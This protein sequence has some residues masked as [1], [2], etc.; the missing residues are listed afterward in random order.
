MI[1]PGKF[2][3]ELASL[4]NKYSMENETNTPDFILAKY[5]IKCLDAWTWSCNR[6]TCW[7]KP[8]ERKND[9]EPISGYDKVFRED[10]KC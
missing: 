8:E 9:E 6:R 3:K 2:E 5:L 4:L 1:V 7:Y 10:G